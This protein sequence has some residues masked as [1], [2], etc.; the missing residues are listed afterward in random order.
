MIDDVIDVL[1]E[2]L[3][4]WLACLIVGGLGL[5]AGV[6][7]LVWRSSE[8]HRLAFCGSS[9]GEMAQFANGGAYGGCSSATTMASI[10]LILAIAGWVILGITLLVTVF[11]A[12][13]GMLLHDEPKRVSGS[14]GRSGS[15]PSAS[16]QRRSAKAARRAQKARGVL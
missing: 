6:G 11:L 16:R 12:S 1:F 8:E 3:P 10:A 14:S 15:R 5:G 2:V 9:A 13:Q 4:N 7:G